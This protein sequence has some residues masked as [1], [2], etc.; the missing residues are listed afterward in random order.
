MG[1]VPGQRVDLFVFCTHAEST[2][3]ENMSGESARRKYGRCSF[4]K[5]V[6]LCVLLAH[7]E[8]TNLESMSG[9]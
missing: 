2:N 9:E 8:S 6:D 1:D 4:Q 7:A 5:G 3:L